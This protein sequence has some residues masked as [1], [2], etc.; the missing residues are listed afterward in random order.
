MKNSG[1]FLHSPFSESNVMKG[2]NR[3]LLLQFILSEIFQSKQSEQSKEPLTKIFFSVSSSFYPLDWSS[4]RGHLNKVIEHTQLMQKA[5]PEQGPAVA[6]FRHALQNTTTVIANHCDTPL[7]N[8]DR[9][10]TLYLKQL[11]LMLEPMMI[12]CI[13]D[14]NFVFFL[15]KNQQMIHS[16]THRSYLLNFLQ[17]NCEE[18]ES[19]S[20]SL[21]DRFHCRGFSGLISEVKASINYLQQINE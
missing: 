16:L 19:L 1:V 13:D 7:E 2:N 5:F 20:K 9:Q 6:I 15:L 10:L 18:I 8:F 14:E 11:F 4:Q 17:K 21:C 3:S 12:E